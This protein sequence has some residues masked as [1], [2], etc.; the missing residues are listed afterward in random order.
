MFGS[1]KAKVLRGIVLGMLAF[2]AST[3]GVQALPIQMGFAIDQSGSITGG[4]FNLMKSGYLAAFGTLPTDGSVEVTVVK[5]GTSVQTVFA[6]TVIT[7]ATLPTLLTA[8]S[9]M[10]QA[11]GN[12]NMGGAIDALRVALTGSANFGGDA[13]INISTDGAP[14]TG[15]DGQSECSEC[16]N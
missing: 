6:P 14:T 9:T 4:E 11:G 8:I 12:T 10:T 16:R 3:V 15:P 5:F 13:L 1:Q 2:A 7:G